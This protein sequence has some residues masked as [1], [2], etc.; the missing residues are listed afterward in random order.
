M[1]EHTLIPA[2]SFCVSHQ[3]DVHFIEELHDFGLVH[4]V[5]KQQSLFIPET[6]LQ[7]LE[8]ILVFNKELDINL[9]GI[10][11]IFQLLERIEGMQNQLIRLENQLKKYE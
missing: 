5:S 11:T 6:E 2:E 10:E 8:R 1:E 7:K 9:A 3:I 4:I